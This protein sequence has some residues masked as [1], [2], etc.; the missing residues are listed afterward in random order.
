MK[1]LIFIIVLN[2]KLTVSHNDLRADTN[3]RLT[4]V[5][6]HPNA[7]KR[8]RGFG[9]K[10]TSGYLLGVRKLATVC[11]VFCDLSQ[12]FIVVDKCIKR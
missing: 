3:D 4:M 5:S 12:H 8:V 9:I 7:V 11:C 10:K 2:G 6:T 1:H